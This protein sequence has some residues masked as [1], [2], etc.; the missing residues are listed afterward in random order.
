[1]G[2]QVA[3][4]LLADHVRALGPQYRAGAAQA[5]LEL[6]VAGFLFPP[7]GA[8]PGQF[9]RG[10]QGGSVMVVIRAISS[11]LPSPS[12][13]GISYSMTRT[14]IAWLS[15]R[16]SPAR[17]AAISLF[18]ALPRRAGRATTDGAALTLISPQN[19]PT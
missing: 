18:R 13:S 3:V 19:G 5:G 11:A 9:L 10:G 16:C 6:I 15:S 4:D 12:R 14:R 17:A 7:L 2:E 1:V 8:G